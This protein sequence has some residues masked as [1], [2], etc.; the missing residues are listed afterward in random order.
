MTRIYVCICVPN[1]RTLIGMAVTKSE[2]LHARLTEEQAALL[3]AAADSTGQTIT[4]F[5]IQASLTHARNV[6]ADRRFFSIPDMAWTEFGVLLDRPVAH[7]PRL[8][9]L[10]EEPS[11]F[12]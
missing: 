10:F 5:T 1:V 3:R 2:R 9:R 12:E 7:K 6:L 8:E 4:D 11:V